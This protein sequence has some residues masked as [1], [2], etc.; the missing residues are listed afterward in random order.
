MT[1]PNERD[2]ETPLNC[3]ECNLAATQCDRRE[4]D[5]HQFM[6]TAVCPLE[7]IWTTKWFAA[8]RSA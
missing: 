5:K 7:H 4:L 3:P 6:L 8:D 1:C 2:I